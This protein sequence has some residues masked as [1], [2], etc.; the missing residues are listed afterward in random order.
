MEKKELW[1]DPKETPTNFQR[2]P[3]EMRLKAIHLTEGCFMMF[4]KLR[5]TNITLCNSGTNIW[6]ER[7]ILERDYVILTNGTGDCNVNYI[8]SPELPIDHLQSLDLNQLCDLIYRNLN[9]V[10]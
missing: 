2:S 5:G 3:L 6:F 1:E 4:N 7:L 9:Y 8:K 10:N